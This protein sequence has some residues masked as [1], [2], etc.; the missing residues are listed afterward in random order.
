MATTKK[1]TLAAVPGL[2]L[3]Y[4][5]GRLIAAG[6]T[7]ADEVLLLAAERTS[8]IRSLEKELAAL[9]AGAARTAAT[10]A[11]PAAR[12][13][14]ATPAKRRTA[15]AAKPKP[16]AKGRVIVRSDGRQFTR[17]A[18]VVAARKLQGQYLGRLR[19]VPAAEKGRFKKLAHDKGVAAA[20]AA[21]DQ[22]LG[23]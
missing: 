6:K 1:G 17:T 16:A 15:R 19:Q 4:A 10:P 12:P 18:K 22:Y 23:R 2:D 7:T 5:V 11:R 9:R 14:V 8:R 21:L 13:K 3:A 20:V